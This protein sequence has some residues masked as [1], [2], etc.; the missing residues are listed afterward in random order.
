MQNI[1]VVCF[2][3]PLPKDAVMIGFNTAAV[4]A[5]LKGFRADDAE[6]LVKQPVHVDI[7]GL[8]ILNWPLNKW[9]GFCPPIRKY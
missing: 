9:W 1:I 8:S 6:A 3:T 5:R 4:V 7:V 2:L